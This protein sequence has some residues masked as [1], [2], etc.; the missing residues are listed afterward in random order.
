MKTMLWQLTANAALPGQF[1]QLAGQGNILNRQADTF[2][3]RNAFRAAA[4]V[5]SRMLT[6]HAKLSTGSF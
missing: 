1:E 5:D 2:E 4:A 6:V 3:E